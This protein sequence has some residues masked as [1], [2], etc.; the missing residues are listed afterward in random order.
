MTIDRVC[1][2]CGSSPGAGQIYLDAA[3]SLG[4]VLVSR[5]IDL[6][7]G[8]AGVGLMGRLADTLI[9]GGRNVTGVMPAAL[10]EREVAHPGVSDLRVVGSMHERKALMMELAD[11]FI[12]MPGGLGTFEELLETL[13]WAQLGIHS[14]PCG[15]LNVGGFFDHLTAFLDLATDRRFIDPS[16]RAL[17][18]ASE[19]PTLLVDRLSRPERQHTDKAAWIHRVNKL[20]EDAP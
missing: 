3:Q 18:V 6:V 20:P 8:G 16:H 15:V 14:K 12:A 10:V 17:L 5:E 4:R 2:F 7:Y 1:V 9:A 13:T 11:A 19:D